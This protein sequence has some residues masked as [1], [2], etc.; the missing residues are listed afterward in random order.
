MKFTI[1]AAI[2]ALPAV[3]GETFK[4]TPLSDIETC[5]PTSND[6]HIGK[7]SCESGY[8]CIADESFDLGGICVSEEAIAAAYAAVYEARDLQEI[9]LNNTIANATNATMDDDEV[10]MPTGSGSPTAAPISPEGGG[11]ASAIISVS[12]LVSM[13]GLVAGM[14]ALN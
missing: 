3:S 2:M 10:D 5:D 7:N 1:A 12:S 6:R 11:S 4:D 9:I 13:V 8:R 14:M